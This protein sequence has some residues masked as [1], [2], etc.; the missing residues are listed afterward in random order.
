MYTSKDIQTVN[1]HP[2]SLH[3]HIPTGPPHSGKTALAAKIAEESQ[4]PFIKICSPDKMIGH[5]EISK[6]QA[7]KKVSAA[8]RLSPFTCCQTTIYRLDCI[9]TGP[10]LTCAA[11]VPSVDL[12]VSS[13]CSPF[14]CIWAS[15][16]LT[17]PTSLSSA[18]SWSMTSSACWITSPSAPVSLT[19]C[20]RLFLCC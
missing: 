2:H 20:F 11:V 16:C 15:R 7:I 19:W 14:L 13:L 12:P 6:C 9:R 1:C 10:L 3:Q 4:F 8:V 18:A 5:S 17:M